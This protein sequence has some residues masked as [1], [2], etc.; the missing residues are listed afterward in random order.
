MRP[1]PADQCDFA[2]RDASK[3]PGRAEF[4]GGQKLDGKRKLEAAYQY[5]YFRS[6]SASEGPGGGAGSP[7]SR[8]C[9]HVGT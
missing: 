3:A 7:P 2:G 4:A 1:T 6:D 9:R 5:Q 8:Y